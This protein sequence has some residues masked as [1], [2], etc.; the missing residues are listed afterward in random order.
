MIW[1]YIISRYADD[2]QLYIS[3]KSGAPTSILVINTTSITT[4]KTFFPSTPL[5]SPFQPLKN[6]SL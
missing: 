3:T 2:N 4:Q 5:T 1:V 6:L